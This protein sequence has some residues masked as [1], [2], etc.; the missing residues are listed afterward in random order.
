MEIQVINMFYLSLPTG[1]SGYIKAC[2]DNNYCKIFFLHFFFKRWLKPYFYLISD[3]L[4]WLSCILII[5]TYIWITCKLQFFSSR[6]LWTSGCE[7]CY[8]EF[9]SKAGQGFCFPRFHR[10]FSKKLPSTLDFSKASN[11]SQVRWWIVANY[12]K[13]FYNNMANC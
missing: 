11:L 7:I 12:L 9:S 6:K 10:F 3:R 4:C 2:S 8:F 13:K 5:K 1:S